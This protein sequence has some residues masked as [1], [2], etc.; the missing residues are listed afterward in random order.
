MSNMNKIRRRF[1]GALATSAVAIPLSGLL[2][3]RQAQAADMPKLSPD[4]PAAKS[5]MYSLKSADANKRCSG[6][7]FY[8]GD[9]DAEW[10]ACMIFPQKLVSAGGV[11][12]SWFKRAG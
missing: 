1:V 8:T 9:A 4:D 7:Q 2:A 3:L 5:L 12:N 6:C 11:C 10:G